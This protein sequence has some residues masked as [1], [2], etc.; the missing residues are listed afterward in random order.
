MTLPLEQVRR[1]FLSDSAIYP[2][3]NLEVKRRFFELIV[4]QDLLTL[5]ED[6]K[7]DLEGFLVCYRSWD[8]DY[9]NQRRPEPQDGNSVVVD[10]VWI[11]PDLRSGKT[12]KKVIR[13]ALLKNVLRNAGAARLYL[14]MRRASLTRKLKH[15]EVIRGRD[16]FRYFD[17]PSFY[18]KY[19]K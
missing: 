12:L 17:Y 1:V 11:R 18:R 5:S 3:D 9:L 2:L 15:S 13:L 7:G 8:G 14:H 6:P 16:V 4:K 10:N 19:A